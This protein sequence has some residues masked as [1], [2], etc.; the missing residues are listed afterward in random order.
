MQG[1]CVFIY[2]EGNF[3]KS[4]ENFAGGDGI[5]RLESRSQFN[6]TV[7]TS[8]RIIASLLRAV[9]SRTPSQKAFHFEFV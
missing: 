6:E 3:R 5:L 4:E 1:D 9:R 7:A 8:T 2:S